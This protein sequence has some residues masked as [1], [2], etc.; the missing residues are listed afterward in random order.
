MRKFFFS[1]K[2]LALTLALVVGGSAWAQITSLPFVADYSDTESPAPFGEPAFVTGNDAIGKVVAVV[3][4]TAEASFAVDGGAYVLSNA[5]EVTVSFTMYNGWLGGGA[6]NTFAVLNS[7]GVTLASLSYNANDCNIV[8]VTLAG[9]TVEDFVVFAGQGSVGSKG[10]NGYANDKQ[11]GFIANTEEVKNNG[12]VTIKIN[13]FGGVSLSFVGG[14]GNVNNTYSA[15]VAEGTKL[16]LA[17]LTIANGSN[18][19]DRATGYGDLTVTSRSMIKVSQDYSDGV[20]DWKSDATDRYTVNINEGGYLTVDAVGNGNNGTTVTGSTVNG[21]AAA[22]ENFTSSEDY[23]LSFDLQLTGGDNQATW[24]HINDA[25]NTSKMEELPDNH[26]LSLNA[27][28][29]S[30]VWTINGNETQTIDLAKTTWYTFTLTKYGKDLFLS[31]APTEGGDALLNQQKIAV[32]STGGG[33]GNMVFQ[34]KRYYAYMAIDNVVLR[35]VVESID[36]PATPVYTY[37]VKYETEDGEQVKESVEREE[38][39]GVELAILDEDKETV[40]VGKS[41]YTY[42]SDDAEGQTAAA[43][44]STVI[45]VLFEKTTVSDYVV[46]Y[47]T[48][49]GTE[50]QE[51]TTHKNALVDTEVTASAGEMSKI[52]VDGVIYNYAS[53][54]ESITVAEDEAKNVITLVFAP[55]EDVTGYYLATYETG[56]TNWTA[57]TGGRYTPIIVNGSSIADRVVEDGEPVAFAN[58]TRFTTV[59]QSAGSRNN[60]GGAVNLASLG[61]DQIDYTFEAKLLLGSSNDQAGTNFLVKNLAGDANIL[62]I[63]QINEKGTTTWT[64]NG[65]T[66]VVLPNSGTYTGETNNNLNN[67]SWYDFKVTVY[68][69]YTFV[70]ITDEEGNAILDKEQVATSALTYGVGALQF[71]SSRYYA[72]FGIDDILVRSVANDDIPDGFSTVAVTVNYVDAEGKTV[73]PSDTVE[74]APGEVVTLTSAYTS[75]FKVDAEGA[76]W[77]AESESAPVKKYIYESDNSEEVVA[78]EGAEVNV[79]FRGVGS[80]RVAMRYQYQDA[81]TN[82]M[83]TKNAAGTNLPFFYDSNVA[84]DILFEGDVQRVYYPYYLLV[85]GYLYKTGANGGDADHYDYTVPEGTST[86]SLSPITWTPATEIVVKKG[87]EGE[88]DVEEEVF[89]TNAVFAE[90]SENIPGMTVV[91]DQYTKI[92]QANGAAGSAIGGDVLVTTLMPGKYTITTASRSGTTNFLVDG[93]VVCTVSTSGT[94]TTVT[95]EEFEVTKPTAL[96]IQEQTATTQYSDYVLIRKTGDVEDASYVVLSNYALA[97]DGAY[98]EDDAVTVVVT[99]DAEIVGSYAESFMLNADFAYTVTDAEGKEVTSGS[100]NPFEVSAGTLNIYVSN[101]QP[102][103]EYTITITGVEVTDFDMETY[104]IVTV[105]TEEGELPSLTF[106]TGI[107]TGIANVE[108]A[109]AVKAD[110]KYLENGQIVIYRGGVKYNAAGAV[111]R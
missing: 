64:V 103:T 77:T 99:Y 56:S 104:D 15:T 98:D 32:N 20:A 2:T 13:S 96:Y 75:D 58:K 38:Y 61:I 44:G 36:I 39:E 34:T 24:F 26:V 76:V 53:G 6:N 60:N 35:D 29:K 92:R 106:K 83:M 88:E 100:K 52:L 48:A 62:A 91:K 89:I 47:V 82:E 23:T 33:L 43:D 107:P 50:L 101:L 95:S 41:Q 7:D 66:T 21:K 40:V 55:I 4:G 105:Y 85:D 57:G 86:L 3:N 9:K 87:E 79:V 12:V 73:K 18:N 51:A 69:G 5:E 17:K 37:T 27:A 84:G 63:Q 1:M 65:E 16:D 93:N 109:P 111:I 94:V 22:G 19:G 72:N 97:C 71:N 10:S 67:Y 68:K 11:Q 80:R 81:E 31:V 90:E 30:T 8:D 45:T 42:I 54:N 108:A 78:E 14:K 74:F 70:T 25:A 46:K 102:E 28:P 110:G 59:D 49:D